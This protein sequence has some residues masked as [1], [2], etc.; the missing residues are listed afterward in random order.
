MTTSQ[1]VGGGLGGTKNGDHRFSRNGQPVPSPVLPW[2][3]PGRKSHS[4][5]RS[6][7]KIP[8]AADQAPRE[9]PTGPSRPTTPAQAPT[10]QPQRISRSS[11]LPSRLSSQH[12]DAGDNSTDTEDIDG[13]AFQTPDKQVSSDNGDGT[14]ELSSLARLREFKESVASSRSKNK[15][16]DVDA[17]ALE[18]MAASFLASASAVPPTPVTVQA[19]QLAP[20]TAKPMAMPTREELDNLVEQVAAE[21]SAKP[22]PTTTAAN[23]P[24]TAPPA[25]SSSA[26]ATIKTREQELKERLKAKR[27]S[28]SPSISNAIPPGISAI[29]NKASEPAPSGPSVKAEPG[30]KGSTVPTKRD[31]LEEGEIADEESKRMKIEVQPPSTAGTTGSRE[32]GQ[33][34]GSSDGLNSAGKRKRA[35]AWMKTTGSGSVE[36]S[37]A[38]D[39]QQPKSNKEK[40]A[41]YVKAE[42]G[43][44]ESR[45]SQ[46]TGGARRD[47]DRDD[48]QASPRGKGSARG[49]H[50][51]RS[52]AAKNSRAAG[53]APAG[54]FK[55]ST[56]SKNRQEVEERVRS[57]EK[58][59]ERERSDRERDRESKPSLAEYVSSFTRIR[60]AADKSGE[61]DLRITVLPRP[62]VSLDPVRPTRRLS[63]TR[64]VTP[65][66][67]TIKP[68]ITLVDPVVLL[69]SLKL[70]QEGAMRRP[71]EV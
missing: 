51:S 4:R 12:P 25:A 23:I 46:D 42:K 60:F 66:T 63:A 19:S 21:T 13:T 11:L 44:L 69:D 64:I 55:D 26:D 1:P 17:G 9:P 53:N 22:V 62:S 30:A 34:T 45:I 68:W 3:Q 50:R 57:K 54:G 8:R 5:S 71:I 40:S 67:D 27:E 52:P 6:P 59:I 56:F 65:G 2:K 61:L 16:L 58:E 32:D 20:V 37:T 47:R 33:V 35:D 15:L 18:E 24:S 43:S 29:I 36:P 10:D 48:G 7:E 41:P 70:P 31:R 28:S 39:G 49:R 14:T 38:A